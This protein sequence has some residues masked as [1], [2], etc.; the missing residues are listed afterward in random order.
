ML[1]FFVAPSEA[2]KNISQFAKYP[3]LLSVK[4]IEYSLCID[5]GQG[6][7]IQYI[8]DEEVEDV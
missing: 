6:T 2:R 3:R 5:D 4:L 7:Y 1:V 8:K